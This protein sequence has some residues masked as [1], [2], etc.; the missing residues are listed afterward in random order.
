MSEVD[1]GRLASRPRLYRRLS[2]LRVCSEPGLLP[3]IEAMSDAHTW[4]VINSVG[5]ADDQLDRFRRVW[6]YPQSARRPL[7]PFLAVGVR[8]EH[9]RVLSYRQKDEA[10]GELAA[11]AQGL[12][13]PRRQVAAME[14]AA[15]ELLLNAL[16]D[17]PVDAEGKARY[18][19][20]TPQQRLLITAQ[21]QDAAWLS[22]AAD[23]Q[24]VVVAVHDPFGRLQRPT[25]L[26]YFRR[27]ALAQEARQ[28]PL[29][30]KAGGAGVGLY[31]VLSSA[32]EL[33]FRLC[34]GR[35]TEVV[36]AIYRQRPYTLR[37]LCFEEY[38]ADP[39]LRAPSDQR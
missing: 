11:W 29:E 12:S 6:A 16:F 19:T 34:P 13:L 15:D 37:T 3:M 23:E 7:H 27:C 21:P 32:S 1:P 2:G 17:A 22:Y 8:R 20:Y 30:H 14:Q 5:L 36:I 38:A 4:G 24:R 33:L 10:V 9:R 31:L 26:D 35:S 25:V 28:S 39:V 18:L